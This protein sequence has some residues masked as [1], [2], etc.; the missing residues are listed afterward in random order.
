VIRRWSTAIGA[1]MRIEAERQAVLFVS[2]GMLAPKKRD[3]ALARRQLYL[4]YGALA[5]ATRCEFNGVPAKLVHGEHERPEELAAR[6]YEA[7]EIR[8][9][10]PVMLSIPSF[11]ALPWAQV[12]CEELVRLERGVQII[13]GGRWVTGPDKGWL[14][15]KLPLASKIVQGLAERQIEHLLGYSQAGS[16]W[17]GGPLWRLNH[18]LIQDYQRY[19]P[20]IEASRGC[21]MRCAFCEERDI[22]LTDLQEPAALVDGMERLVEDYGDRDIHPYLQSSYFL[23]NLRWAGRLADETAR[24]GIKLA[25]RT[26]SRVDSIRP[27]TVERL[28]EAGLKVLDLGLES[29]APPQIKAM[30]KA[31]NPQRYLKEASRLLEA[32]AQHGVWAKVNV[33][34]YAGESAQTLRQ[35]QDWLDEHAHCIKGVSVGPVVVYGPPRHSAEFMRELQRL[36]AS[37]VDADSAEDLGVTALH[38]SSTLDEGEVEARALELSRRYMSQTDYFDLK[39]FSYYPRDYTHAQFLADVAAS[40]ASRLPFRL[41]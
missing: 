34:L 27:K 35:T 31:G 22:P 24:R 28:A 7:G 40:D 12:F 17:Q 26:E 5:L 11:Y 9:D 15:G 30:N 36:G 4:N 25:W 1:A 13:V 6:L 29:A 10:S 38:L 16:Q 37:P 18:R 14:A 21:G 39:R 32:C 20:S 19:Q 33:M 23:P 3:H 2:A 8:S 41:Q